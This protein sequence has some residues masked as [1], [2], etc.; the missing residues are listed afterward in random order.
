MK[1][2]TLNYQ[3]IC[4]AAIQLLCRGT[5]WSN[6]HL[7]LVQHSGSTSPRRAVP[8]ARYTDTVIIIIIFLGLHVERV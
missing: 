5:T 6:E 2:T 3:V 1:K 8:F 4:L 7:E